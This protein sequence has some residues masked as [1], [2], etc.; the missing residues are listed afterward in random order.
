MFNAFLSNFM[1]KHVHSQYGE[2]NVCN[3][4][5]NHAALRCS[6]HSCLILCISMS[7]CLNMCSTIETV[8]FFNEHESLLFRNMVDK[9]HDY[10][11]LVGRFHN[12]RDTVRSRWCAW[13]ESRCQQD[14]FGR[15]NFPLGLFNRQPPKQE[16]EEKQK[17]DI[18]E[19]SH[20]NRWVTGRE[21]I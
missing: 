15:S 16:E 5:V 18:D 7:R 9:L 11:G 13:R 10:Q 1:Y 21:E 20:V 12:L 3:W 19:F 6:M 2:N 17:K 14:N 4:N 8:S